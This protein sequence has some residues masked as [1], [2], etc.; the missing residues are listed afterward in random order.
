MKSSNLQYNV[1]QL[2]RFIFRQLQDVDWF[3]SAKLIIEQGLMDGNVLAVL[4]DLAV[5]HTF[6]SEDT[7]EG[8]FYAWLRSELRKPYSS[9]AK[10]SKTTLSSS[11]TNA[12]SQG[13]HSQGLLQSSHSSSP[14]LVKIGERWFVPV[15]VIPA[16]THN[17]IYIDLIPHWLGRLNG[18]CLFPQVAAYHIEGTNLAPVP[19]SFWE[20]MAYKMLM[21][22]KMLQA[23]EVAS[24]VGYSKWEY[25][26]LEM[27]PLILVSLEDLEFVWAETFGNRTWREYQIEHCPPEIVA[28]LQKAPAELCYQPLWEDA[29]KVLVVD[30]IR[31]ASDVFQR[32]NNEEKALAA[33]SA[34]EYLNRGGS[35]DDWPWQIIVQAKAAEMC[36]DYQAK[37]AMPSKNQ[38]ATR[39]AKW[40]KKE[41]IHTEHG[42]TPS[43][44]YIYRHVLY[45]WTPPNKHTNS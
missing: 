40:C 12:E 11:E 5:D 33:Q 14:Y 2:V 8:Q 22:E 39:L 41:G 26:T 24:G 25:K 36:L 23:K 28:T 21:L 9:D 27:L 31:A 15:H 16:F 19:S 4:Q 34:D 20:G 43:A 3:Q 7:Q 13:L 6:T 35:Q 1:E 29:I 18:F 38:L 10:Q 30:K 17:E 37:G 32:K 45:R 44:S 42:R